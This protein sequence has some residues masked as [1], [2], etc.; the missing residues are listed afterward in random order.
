LGQFFYVNRCSAGLYLEFVFAWFHYQY[1]V[2]FG[3]N[4][5]EVRSRSCLEVFDY[6]SDN[7]LDIWYALPVFYVDTLTAGSSG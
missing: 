3:F 7:G 5:V 2:V 1:Y 4:H 6:C